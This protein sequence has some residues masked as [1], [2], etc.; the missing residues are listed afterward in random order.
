MQRNM[1]FLK[2]NEQMFSITDA[3]EKKYRKSEQSEGTSLV[4]QWLRLHTPANAGELSLIPSW[5]T[6]SHNCHN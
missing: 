5:G 3:Q 6:R 2:L 4:V 1:Y